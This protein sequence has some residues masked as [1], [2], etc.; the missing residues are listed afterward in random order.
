MDQDDIQRSLGRIEGKVES[1][2]ID[3]RDLR[4]NSTMEIA[5]LENRIVNI[6]KK[7]FAMWTFGAAIFAGALTLLKRWWN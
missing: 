5:S 6:E 7:Q 1:L 4:I 2:I 3:I